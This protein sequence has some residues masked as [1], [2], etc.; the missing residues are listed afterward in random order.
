[1][2]T[3]QILSHSPC[4][5]KEGDAK[6]FA[7]KFQGLTWRKCKK[8]RLCSRPRQ[9]FAIDKC[10]DFPGPV[11]LMSLNYFVKIYLPNHTRKSTPISV[12]G[13]RELAEDCCTIAQKRKIY[14]VC[15][16]QFHVKTL[17]KLQCSTESKPVKWPANE[18]PAADC[19]WAVEAWAVRPDGASFRSDPAPGHVSA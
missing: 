2:V 6:N 3:M 13:P 4:N 16:P 15:T 5:N 12:H 11:S 17:Q 1:L 9:V 18:M 8:C 10:C 7:T 19:Q 14:P